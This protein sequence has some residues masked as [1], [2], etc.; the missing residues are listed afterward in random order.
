MTPGQPRKTAQ[1]NTDRGNVETERGEDSGSEIGELPPF[2]DPQADDEDEEWA[3]RE[4]E[5]VESENVR[6][7]CPMCFSLLSTKVQRHE[8]FEGQ[9]R[10]VFVRNC[11]IV[12]SHRVRVK[13]DNETYEIVACRQCETEVGV[14]DKEMVYHFWNVME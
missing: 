11:K 13:Q 6:I 9:F 14:R 12:K 7:S 4:L 5:D 3:K 8:R 2:F 10:A 1:V